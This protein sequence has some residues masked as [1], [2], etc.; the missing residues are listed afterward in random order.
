MHQGLGNDRR[1]TR[2]EDI[3]VCMSGRSCL[4]RLREEDHIGVELRKNQLE[5]EGRWVQESLELEIDEEII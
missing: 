3:L 1:K 2:I 5:E 4:A